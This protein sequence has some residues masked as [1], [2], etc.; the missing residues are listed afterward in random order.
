MVDFYKDNLE[1]LLNEGRLPFRKEKSEAW[2]EIKARIETSQSAPVYYMSTRFPTLK[3]AAGIAVLLG[4]IGFFVFAIGAES[5]QGVAG[6]KTEITLPDGSMIW[7]N[8]EADASYNKWLWTFSREVEL[9]GEAFFD[10]QKGSSFMVQGEIGTVEVLGT[11]FLVNTTSKDFLVACKSGRVK[12]ATKFGS[13]IVLNP[14]ML[15]KAQNDELT[16]ETI[17]INKIA[18]WT[19]EDYVFENIPASELFEIISDA[20]GY[21]F[22]IEAE[23]DMTY[24]GQFSKNQPI[25]EVLSIICLPMNLNF[26]LSEDTIII[27]NK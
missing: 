27:T 2:N 5:H 14:G 1:G 9:H 7:L 19:T 6:S 25:E 22:I 24:S 8:G 20:T 13:S 11:S 4:A 23:L 15:A 12:V 18:T 3:V 17:A 21:E 16:T 26:E 10:V